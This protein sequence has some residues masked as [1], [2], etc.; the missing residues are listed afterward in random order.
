MENNESNLPGT[1]SSFRWFLGWEFVWFRCENCDAIVAHH[2][3]LYTLVRLI[4]RQRKE[5]WNPLPIYHRLPTPSLFPIVPFFSY[6]FSWNRWW[7]HARMLLARTLTLGPRVPCWILDGLSSLAQ[8]H[9]ETTPDWLHSIL[10]VYVKCVCSL[11]APSFPQGAWIKRSQPH[12]IA[13]VI[14]SNG[15]PN[16]CAS[17]T[18]SYA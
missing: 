1:W 14:F 11:L 4:Y 5:E 13:S 16:T 2:S 3:S 18:N 15:T 10:S 9:F 17:H 6:V 8:T 12:F 7:I